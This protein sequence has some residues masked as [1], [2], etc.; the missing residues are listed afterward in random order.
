VLV[1]QTR[2]IPLG[3]MEPVGSCS[4]SERFT[5]M[6]INTFIHITLSFLKI[7]VLCYIIMKCIHIYAITNFGNVFIYFL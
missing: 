5:L 4:S 3:K 7:T 2:E 6:E 1:Y